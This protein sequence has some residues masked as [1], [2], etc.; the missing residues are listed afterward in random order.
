M[1]NVQKAW[2]GFTWERI[3]FELARTW[4]SFKK[5]PAPIII[6]L[7]I[8]ALIFVQSKGAGKVYGDMLFILIGITLLSWFFTTIAHGNYKILI[9]TL[10]LLTVGTMLQCIFRQEEIIAS[11][12][13]ISSGSAALS[14][15]IQYIL[16]FVVAVGAAF[17]YRKFSELSALK[18]CK[19]FIVLSIV[20]SMAT[21]VLAKSVGNVRNWITIGGFSF[22]TTEVVKLL[23][24]FIASALLG[25]EDAPS[26]KRIGVFYA[27]TGI[28]LFFLVLQSEFGT[29]LLLLVVFFV[30][31][32]LFVPGKKLFLSTA[33]VF[34]VGVVLVMILGN[35]LTGLAAKGNILGS[36]PISQIFLRNYN[37]IANRF[38]FWLDPM[39][40]PQG[41]GYQLIQ[42]KNSILLGGWF[43]TSSNVDLPVKTS[44]LVYPALIQRCGMVFGVIV[45]IIFILNWTE[46]VRLFVRKRDRYHCAM[47]AGLTFMFFAQ[48]L[49]IIGGSTGLCPLTGITLPFISSGGSSLLVSSIM[50]GLLIAISGNVQW[51]GRNVD[52]DEFFKK[53]KVLTKCC[54]GLRNLYAHR[55]GKDF[56]HRSGDVRGGGSGEKPGKKS[57]LPKGIRKGKHSR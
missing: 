10:L 17:F 39:K 53:G 35:G 2:A 36:N 6:L 37:K 47:A 22:Q 29:L 26:K 38:I 18:W 15:Q 20:L 13:E 7:Q 28:N 46:S 41:L 19:R 48:A 55:P 33:A 11:G 43:G 40:D 14:L 54:A 8:V 31:L 3:S 24:V 42:A 32:F 45:F 44:D 1:S 52:E 21:L 4:H 27:V 30:Y 16:G 9:Y 57:Y 56:R 51:K 23:Y 49:I 25:T 34:A 50:V 12:Q 5:G